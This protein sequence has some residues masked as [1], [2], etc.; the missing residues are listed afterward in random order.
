MDPLSITVSVATLLRC[1]I[2]VGVSLR[3]FLIGAAEVKIVITAMMVDLRALRSVLE[4]MEITFEEMN[5]DKPETGHIGAHWTNLF[6]SLEDGQ[7]SLAE[8]QKVLEDANKHVKI[9]DSA[10]KQIRVKAVADKIV[11]CRQEVQ[12]Y[13]DT[14]QL[15]LQT[16]IL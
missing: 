5:S 1:C 15:S 12:I 13:K 3:K 10:R 16:I 8:L 11:T 4:S 2:S 6:Q 7:Q 9:L 14:L